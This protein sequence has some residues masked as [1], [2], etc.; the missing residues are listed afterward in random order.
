MPIPGTNHSSWVTAGVPPCLRIRTAS[1]KVPQGRVIGSLPTSV[2][3]HP[4]RVTASADGR[5]GQVFE[6]PRAVGGSGPVAAPYLARAGEDLRIHRNVLAERGFH[7]IDRTGVQREDAH[8]PNSVGGNTA[9]ALHLVRPLIP[10]CEREARV[11]RNLHRRQIADQL[12]SV[13]LWR[14]LQ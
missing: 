9:A 3:C 11:V 4:S 14:R 12:T 1:A 5:L 2:Y 13:Y 6:L 10:G 7:S 8:H